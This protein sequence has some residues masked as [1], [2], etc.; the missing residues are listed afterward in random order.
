MARGVKYQNPKYIS[1]V[2]NG[3]QNK[4]IDEFFHRL[5]FERCSNL[6]FTSFHQRPV[7][8]FHSIPPDGLA[9]SLS[10]KCQ[11][12]NTNVNKITQHSYK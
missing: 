7:T 3:Y 5:S 2:N 9:Q 8:T 6:R 10:T 12:Q 4:H 11:S 1:I